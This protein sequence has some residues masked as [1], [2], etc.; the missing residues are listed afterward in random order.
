MSASITRSIVRKQ[1]C[2]MGC[3]RFEIGVLRIGRTDVAPQR[4]SA[5]QIDAAISRGSDG[6]MRAAH[7]YSSAHT[8]LMRSAWSTMSALTR[9]RDD[10]VGFQPAVV[11][12]TSPGNFQV[13]LN[14]G[15]SALR[16]RF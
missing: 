10:R 8:A 16:S 7:T 6:R 2:A 11:V 14:H 15:R 12:E 5:D 13:W 1:L 9:S 3:E 4:W